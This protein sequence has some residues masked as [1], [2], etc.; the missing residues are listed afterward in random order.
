MRYLAYDRL[1][2]A[3][4]R[5]LDDLLR[6]MRGVRARAAAVPSVDG[7]I[8]CAVVLDLAVEVPHVRLGVAV[9]AAEAGFHDPCHDLRPTTLRRMVL[10]LPRRYPT[11]TGRVVERVTARPPLPVV[12]HEGTRPSREVST[13]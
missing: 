13:V 2:I 8:G 10:A 3:H 6:V 7:P 9:D 5:R 4:D 1:R 12:P 11:A